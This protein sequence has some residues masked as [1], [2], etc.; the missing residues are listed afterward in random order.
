MET[1]F[2]LPEPVVVEADPRPK[3]LRT[4]HERHGINVQH[5]CGECGHLCRWQYNTA[6]YFKCKNYTPW[7]HGPGTDWR[8]Y[9]TA[10]G[11]FKEA[12]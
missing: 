6:V 10:C 8:K 2:E 3:Q 1:L 11:L 4:M 12:E 5:I 7:T 9:W